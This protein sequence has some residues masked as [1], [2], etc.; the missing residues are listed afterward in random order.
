MPSRWPMP[1]EKPLERFLATS[2]RPTTPST[3]STRRAGMPDSWARHSRWLASAAAA[4]HRLRVEQRADLAGSVRQFAV[5][6]AADGDL[7]RGRRVQTEDHPHRRRLAGAVGSE[8]AGHRSGPYLER[9]VVHG[10]LGAVALRQADCLDHALPL[11][12]VVGARAPVRLRRLNRALT[13]P[14]KCRCARM[15]LAGDR[16]PEPAQHLVEPPVPR[17]RHRPLADPERPYVESEQ[18]IAGEQGG[19]WNGA[20]GVGERLPG[21]YAGQAERRETA[22]VRCHGEPLRVVVRPRARSPVTGIPRAGGLSRAAARGRHGCAPRLA[23]T[24][25][26]SSAAGNRPPGPRSPTAP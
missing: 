22:V 16:L 25:P 26:A 14:A 18:L 13:V 24:R 8:E 6:V 5:R 17:A 9:Q 2:C 23:F 4:V 1:S 10:R 21:G 3:S 7:A 11:A 20:A 12:S 15:P 19:S